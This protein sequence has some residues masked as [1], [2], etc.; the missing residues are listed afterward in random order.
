MAIFLLVPYHTRRVGWWGR[1]TTI[2]IA[3]LKR[4]CRDLELF[5]ITHCLDLLATENR[6]RVDAGV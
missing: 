5:I 1:G 4:K 6:H 2:T 3:S